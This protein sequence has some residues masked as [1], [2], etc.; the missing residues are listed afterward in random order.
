VIRKEII[1]L[2]NSGPTPDE[3]EKGKKYLIGSYA[4]RFDT[5]AKI[6]GQLVHIQMDGFGPEWLVERNLR[7]EAVTMDDAQRVARRLFGDGGLSVAVV[8]RPV[9]L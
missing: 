7:I 8:G 4:L 3:L 1:D 9:G 2:A 5:S 6:A